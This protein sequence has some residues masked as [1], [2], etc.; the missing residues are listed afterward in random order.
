M[1]SLGSIT[2]QFKNGTDMNKAIADLAAAGK[3]HY[4]AFFLDNLTLEGA[5][6]FELIK[7]TGNEKLLAADKDLN[8]V[9]QHLTKALSDPEAWL[10]TKPGSVTTRRKNLI[11]FRDELSD[12]VA[13]IAAYDDMLGMYGHILVRKMDWE[14]DTESNDEAFAGELINFIFEYEDSV[15]IN[16]RIKS[17]YGELPVRMSRMKFQ[18]W[19]EKALIGMKGVS[20]RDLAN[21]TEYLKETYWPE[22]VKGYGSVLPSMFDAMLKI[23]GE[24]TDILGQ[25]NIDRLYDQVLELKR[26]IEDS[27]NLY[28]FTASVLNNMI[29]VLSVLDE[30]SLEASESGQRFVENMGRLSDRRKEDEIIDDVLV[31]A[32]DKMSL[33]F[34]SFMTDNGRYDG[35]FEE[36]KTGWIDL[37]VEMDLQETY[38]RLSG[39]YVL[40]SSSYFAPLSVEG[41]DL[42]PVDEK[43]LASVTKSLVADLDEANKESSRDLKRARMANVLGVLNII[44]RTP[45]EVHTYILNALTGCRDAKEKA[46]CKKLLTEMISY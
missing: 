14:E 19:V 9:V 30:T 21:Y 11:K 6:F 2:H 34:D 13:V 27:V 38:D 16:D 28:T 22:S 12:H 36:A 41:Q 3:A 44:H 26:I 23:G 8:K 32:F 25:D 40:H 33:T 15:S 17:I 7:E 45:Q 29:G 18:E 4:L 20:V 24:M 43:F 35:L 39:L 42:T 1:S 5:T 31:A 46:A 37:I 10:N